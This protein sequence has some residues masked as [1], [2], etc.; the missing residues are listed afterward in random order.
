MWIVGCISLGEV[1]FDFFYRVK[2]FQKAWVSV[3]VAGAFPLHTESVGVRFVEGI[4]FGKI[5]VH[6]GR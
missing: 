1:S 4:S 5:S 2:E 6:D 3:E